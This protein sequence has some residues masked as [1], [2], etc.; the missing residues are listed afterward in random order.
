LNELDGVPEDVVSAAR[1]AAEADGKDGYKLTLK[2]PCYLP[3]MQF[4]RS[5]ALRETLYRAY[6]TRAS[7]FGDRGLRQHRTDHERS[8]RCAQEE[9]KLLGYRNFGELSVVPKMAESPEQVVKFLRDLA[10]KAKP[11]GERD[12]ADLRA[13]CRKSNSSITRS[14]ALGL[15]LHRREAQGSALRLQR[16][17]GEAV[18]PRAEGDGGP[19]QDRRDAVR[20]VDPPRQRAGVAPERGVLPHRARRPEGRAVLPRPIRPRRQ[21]RRRLDGRRARPLAAPRRRHAADAGRAAGVQLREKA[22]TASR[23]CSRTTM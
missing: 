8:S 11:Y 7:E 2:M 16:A 17:G 20:G 19:L 14:A 18:L 23:R 1:S 9:A 22:W 6:V 3:V 12:L 13:V 10:T 4:A 21:A 5:S 15:E